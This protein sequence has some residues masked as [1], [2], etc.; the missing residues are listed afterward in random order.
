MRHMEV[1]H[2][3]VDINVAAVFLLVTGPAAGD[4]LDAMGP[5]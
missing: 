2:C 3:T 1:T 5:K 4:D